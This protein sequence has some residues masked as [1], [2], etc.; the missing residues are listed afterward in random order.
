MGIVTLVLGNV[1]FFLLDILLGK[2]PIK[3]L[4]K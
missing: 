1:V 4:R 2:F 3:R